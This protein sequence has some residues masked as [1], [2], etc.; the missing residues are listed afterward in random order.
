MCIR[1]IPLS[2]DRMFFA[3]FDVPAMDEWFL[4][5][6]S[7][8]QVV[9][10]PE[11]R[12]AYVGNNNI[13]HA[14]L[15]WQIIS[16]VSLMTTE[17]MITMD[18]SKFSDILQTLDAKTCEH[19]ARKMAKMLGGS[20]FEKYLQAITDIVTS[21]AVAGKH[22][23]MPYFQQTKKFFPGVSPDSDILERLVGLTLMSVT[24]RLE[25]YQKKGS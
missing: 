17:E 19:H 11:K 18:P 21:N 12:Y 5:E 10:M 20:T 4:P 3:G 24:L 7:L 23:V 9:L 1:K 25:N 16:E 22:D 13:A 6:I 8:E 2:M 15:K 14:P